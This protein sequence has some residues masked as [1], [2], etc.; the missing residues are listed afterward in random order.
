M[1]PED[2]LKLP[3]DASILGPLTLLGFV[4]SEGIKFP[5]EIDEIFESLYI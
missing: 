3:D 2:V 1:K 4:S 5:Y